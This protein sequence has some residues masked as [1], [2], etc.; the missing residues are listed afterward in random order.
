MCTYV[1]IDG[2]VPANSE[3]HSLRYQLTEVGYCI[4]MSALCL[5]WIRINKYK[6]HGSKR[7][8]KDGSKMSKLEGVNMNDYKAQ[9]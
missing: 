5:S 7:L 3:L 8:E 6:C 4:K 1:L 9:Q 2:E